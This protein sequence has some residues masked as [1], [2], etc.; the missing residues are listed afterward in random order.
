MSTEDMFER[1]IKSISSFYN[2]SKK[3]LTY[4]TEEQRCLLKQNS[5]DLMHHWIN[6]IEDEQ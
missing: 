3:I 5:N 2:N 4:E 6:A 1:K